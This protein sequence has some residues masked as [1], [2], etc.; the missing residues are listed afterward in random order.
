MVLSLLSLRRLG[1][2]SVDLEAQLTASGI[3]LRSTPRVTP[4][5]ILP[6]VLALAGGVGLDSRECLDSKSNS[7]ISRSEQIRRGDHSKR[8]ECTA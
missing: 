2:L 4:I 3:P 7:I 1:E 8:I 5:T 6:G